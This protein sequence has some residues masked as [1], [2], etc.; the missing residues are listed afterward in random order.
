MAPQQQKRSWLAGNGHVKA[1]AK[2]AGGVAQA[3]STI[4]FGTQ[5]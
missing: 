1:G 2:Q 4:P 3:V 5:L